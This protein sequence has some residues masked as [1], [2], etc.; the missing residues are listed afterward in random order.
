[1]DRQLTF[2]DCENSG[3]GGKKAIEFNPWRSRGNVKALHTGYLPAHRLP[4]LRRLRFQLGFT[5]PLVTW[6]A[7]LPWKKTSVALTPHLPMS[8]ALTPLRLK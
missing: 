6:A 2:P 8:L 3:E 4:Q 5:A 7:P 1:M